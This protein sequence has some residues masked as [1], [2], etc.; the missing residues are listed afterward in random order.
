MSICNSFTKSLLHYGNILYDQTY[1][2]S[3]HQEIKKMQYTAAFMKTGAITGASKQS[4]PIIRLGVPSKETV[5]EKTVL[6]KIF[7]KNQYSGSL[8]D[9]IPKSDCYYQT[10]NCKIISQF[11]ISHIFFKNSFQSAITEWNKLDQ[12]FRISDNVSIF[13]RKLLIFARS[14]P[15][16]TFNCHHSEG[17][18]LLTRFRL[19]LS[20]LDKHKFKH[21]S[22]DAPNPSCYCDNGDIESSSHYFLHCSLYLNKGTAFLDNITRFHPKF[23]IEVTQR[24]PKFSF[25]VN[26]R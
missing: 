7:N 6:F 13:E 2:T 12:N 19:V 10:R 18:K 24:L 21:S 17:I 14:V 1:D 23:L 9:T 5:A 16:S 4:L 11:R 22:Q 20:H 8:F 26:P 3:F 15:I 25:S